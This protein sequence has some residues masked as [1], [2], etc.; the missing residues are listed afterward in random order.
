MSPG[1]RPII[2]Q[3]QYSVGAGSK[4]A[5][6]PEC[7]KRYRDAMGGGEHTME[8]TLGIAA[9]CESDLQKKIFFRKNDKT[10]VCI[11]EEP[12]MASS[13]S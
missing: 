5:V 4:S 2:S 11:F 13:R 9:S 8:M 3:L 10:G 7:G 1:D 6:L 12:Q